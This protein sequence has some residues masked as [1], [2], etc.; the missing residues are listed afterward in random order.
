MNAKAPEIITKVYDF[1]LYFI[2]KI[3]K[4]PK[5]QKYLLGD[6]LEVGALSVLENLIE[7]VYSKE[8][9]AILLKSNIHLEKL[10]YMLRLSKDLKLLDLHSYE[11]ASKMLYELGNQLG[12]WIKQ[13]RVRH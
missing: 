3:S 12:G 2:P 6:R 4:F 9:L 7:A 13:Q 10:R 1:L 5:N 8:K 11:V